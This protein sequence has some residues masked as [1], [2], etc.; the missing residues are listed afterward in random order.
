MK[1]YIVPFLIIGMLGVMII[2]LPAWVLDFFLCLN[3][4]FAVLF[5]VSSI[6]LQEPGRFTS[7]PTLLL[8]CTIFRLSLN[9]STTRSVLA[10]NDIPSVI[11]AFADFVVEGNLIV[12][13]VVFIIITIVQFLVI[14]KGAER[15]AEVAARFTLDA[16]PGKQMAIDADLRSGAITLAEARTHRKDLHIESKLFGSLDGAMK[17]VKGDAIAGILITTVNIFAGVIIGCAQQGLSFSL[18]LQR[19]GIFTIGD[20]LV[21][22]MPALIVAAAAGIA[23]TRV[24]DEDQPLLGR[25]I[26]NQIANDPRVLS[27]AA[28]VMFL[29]AIVPGLPFFPFITLS[30]ML[31]SLALSSKANQ[32]KKVDK[33]EIVPFFSNCIS[34]A[35]SEK[36]VVY[37]H[38]DLNSNQVLQ[39]L[40]QDFFDTWG[41]LAPDYQYRLK[42]EL[43][44]L[45]AVIEFQGAGS[46][47]I[48]DV[49]NI[50]QEVKRFLGKHKADFI[51]DRFTKQALELNQ[52]DEHTRNVI[53][54]VLSYTSLT[55]V[56]RK[57]I[58][59]DVSIRQFS[60]VIQK[61][62]EFFTEGLF[63]GLTSRQ[64]EDLLVSEIRIGLSRQIISQQVSSGSSKEI[65]AI[66][67]NP[68]LDHQLSRYAISNEV[69]SS[70]L[71]E[72]L[73]L[74]IKE[75]K[76]EHEDFV[77][78]CSKFT[79]SLLVQLINYKIKV[80]SL[81]EVEQDRLTAGAKLEIVSELKIENKAQLNKAQL[82]KTRL[83]AVV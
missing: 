68:A 70:K 39:Q 61:I 44:G 6:F 81:D 46:I 76:A 67:L 23:I 45:Q 11:S 50:S 36:A 65:R 24:A 13:A 2:P 58:K 63:T 48:N 33:L 72:D 71:M 57:L 32:K 77:F 21:S 64:V 52:F 20:G 47:Y 82:N 49:G 26:A 30:I 18:A 74:R 59:E 5:L 1:D 37:L 80:F 38:N 27:T 66:K 7:L 28:F 60:I 75:L 22:Q 9:I 19:Y 54:E 12:G 8:L 56:I 31:A 62:M 15:V 25:A 3:L 55:R 79:R 4:A 69:I 83:K 43:T 35:L 17:F 14:A 10:G 16:M 78:V 34:I 40:R 41:V 51:D 29:L 73:M 42:S 53:P